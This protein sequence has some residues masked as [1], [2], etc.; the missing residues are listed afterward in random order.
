MQ[1]RGSQHG[2]RVSTLGGDHRSVDL[3]GGA[4]VELQLRVGID[5]HEFEHDACE[6]ERQFANVVGAA[7]T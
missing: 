3:V 1:R 2:V 7:A 6:P 5:A 4:V